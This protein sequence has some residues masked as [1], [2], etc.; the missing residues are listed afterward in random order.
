M[1][2]LGHIVLYF[3]LFYVRLMG[4]ITTDPPVAITQFVRKCHLVPFAMVGQ[5]SIDCENTYSMFNVSI[6][7]FVLNRFVSVA[8]IHSKSH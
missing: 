7:N 2:V 3:N 4:I 8:Y 1:S 6:L 5:N